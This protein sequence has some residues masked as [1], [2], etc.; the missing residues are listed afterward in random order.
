MLTSDKIYPIIESNG[1]S[2][3]DQP[4]ESAG[5]LRSQ[6][7]GPQIKFVKIKWRFIPI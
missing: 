6:H 5:A 1:G 7:E 3:I 4:T 2:P